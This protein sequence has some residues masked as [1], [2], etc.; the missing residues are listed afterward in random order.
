MKPVLLISPTTRERTQLPAVAADL[1]LRLLY[2]EFD[3]DYFDHF[4]GRNPD[5]ARPKID[6]VQLIERTAA[7]YRAAGL[8]GVTSAVGYPGMSAASVIARELGLPGP[9]PEAVMRCDHKY[10]SRL[11]QRRHVREATP[12]FRLI[13]PHDPRSLDNLL[14]FPSF[15]K[16]VK[17]CMS[18]NACEVRSEQEL[19]R[20]VK[21]AMQPQ[22]FVEPFNEMLRAYTDFAPN[23]SCLLQ[24]T[25]L[26]GSQVSLEGLV[27]RGEVTVLGIID[28]IVFPG[29]LAFKR[30]QYPSRLPADV[31]ARMTEI[32]TGFFSGIG[33]D[34]AMFNMELF[35]D[36]ATDAIA[37]IE[38]NPKIASQ[39]PGLFEKVDGYSTYR[40]LLEVATG[41]R[42]RTLYRKGAHK[43]AASC[44]LRTFEDACVV[45][46]PSAAEIASV[47]KRFPDT[48]V[49]IC[50]R[51]GRS[52]SDEVQDSCS[53]R[54]GLIELGASDEAEVGR[55]FEECRSM[56]TFRFAPPNRA[57]SRALAAST[58]LA[59]LTNM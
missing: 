27:F 55:S 29:T 32:A 3:G 9:A 11:H 16:P 50:A 1:G 58:A 52:L 44:V 19:R 45:A 35:Y 26:Q 28:A 40:T 57:I 15:L 31:Q 25:L 18:R 2:E 7:K 17:S 47:T 10:Y 43:V 24:E 48:R 51:A 30:F 36:A 4:L 14:P 38:V 23:A 59:C 42:P 21:T 53:F 34:N 8:A 5:F 49:Q 20:L 39:F 46:I 6:V 41:Q 56:L 22:R 37:I 33:Y 13:D 12:E 54:Y